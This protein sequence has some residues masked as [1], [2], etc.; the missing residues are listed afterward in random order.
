MC[1]WSTKRLINT[2]PTYYFY[3]CVMLA[4]K[5]LK[6]LQ[7]LE[8]Y[9]ILV[10]THCTQKYKNITMNDPLFVNRFKYNS[11]KRAIHLMYTQPS[12]QQCMWGRYLTNTRRV[13]LVKGWWVVVLREP[14]V[15]NLKREVWFKTWPCKMTRVRDKSKWFWVTKQYR[16]HSL[17]HFLNTEKRGR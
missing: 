5:G 14:A 9:I 1:L 6:L 11:Q 3:I 12:T 4:C 2:S 16:N 13:I 7:K 15:N 8:Q 17:S 10:L